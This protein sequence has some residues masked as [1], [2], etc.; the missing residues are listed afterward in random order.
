[1]PSKSMFVVRVFDQ[2][3]DLKKV[4][5]LLDAVSE[6]LG[7]EEQ[8]GSQATALV[9]R[10]RVGDKDQAALH[11]SAR[12]Y[13]PKTII[14]NEGPDNKMAKKLVDHYNL[15]D[16]YLTDEGVLYVEGGGRAGIVIHDLIEEA[17]NF[18]ASEEQES[19]VLPFLVPNVM[20][21]L[22]WIRHF[23]DRKNFYLKSL[24]VRPYEFRDIDRAKLVL[25]L[26]K[27]DDWTTIVEELGVGLYSA[28]MIFSG[29]DENVTVSV[30]SNGVFVVASKDEQDVEAV[31]SEIRDYIRWIKT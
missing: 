16:A 1:M 23:Q 18:G 4:E 5:E 13:K 27:A 2:K 20:S 28:S 30:S 29:I 31:L 21:I 6:N 24:T 19:I 25:K 17:M 11:I 9:S 15:Y 3:P 14:C 7:G 10:L 12:E 22:D 26:R 8:P